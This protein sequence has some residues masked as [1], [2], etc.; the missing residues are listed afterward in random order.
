MIKLPETKTIYN[1][2]KASAKKRNILFNLTIPQLN[3]FTYPISCIVCNTPLEYGKNLQDNSGTFDRID[4]NLGYIE[5]NL[6]II[7]WRCNRLKNNATKKEL[8]QLSDF[9]NNI[10]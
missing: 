1:R 9:Y 10:F 2:L 3:N 4:S 7:C 8:K 5:E 6:I